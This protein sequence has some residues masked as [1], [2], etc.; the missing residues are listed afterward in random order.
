MK[1]DDTHSDSEI[2]AT[3]IEVP[4]ADVVWDVTNV[5]D[6]DVEG[7]SYMK[8]GV[9]LSANT[10]D[11][12][13]GWNDTGNPTTDGIS[14]QVYGIG[15]F[16]FMAPAG[17]KFTKIEMTLIDSMGWDFASLGTGW[18]F[19]GDGTNNIYKVTWTGSAASTDKLLPDTNDFVGENVKSI[20]FYLSE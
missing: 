5:T 16:T 13:A 15:G 4:V 7:D 12:F 8:E 10:E 1:G 11:V 14:F 19:V 2:A 6:I 3:A 18:T 17:K 9:T 20:A